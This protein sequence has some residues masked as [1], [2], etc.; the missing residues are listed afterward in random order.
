MKKMLLGFLVLMLAVP[1]FAGGF[2][3]NR[4]LIHKVEDTPSI[5]APL[6]ELLPPDPYVIKVFEKTEF[7]RVNK[8]LSVG[9]VNDTPVITY[10]LNNCVLEAGVNKINNDTKA[11]ARTSWFFMPDISLNLLAN[12]YS[13]NNIRLN[14]GIGFEEIFDKAALNAGVYVGENIG[15]V[16]LGARIN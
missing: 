10:N 2:A 8:K 1:C 11:L 4:D 3:G 6:N 15:Q 12:A 9:F 13:L 7:K 16:I 5:E 14:L